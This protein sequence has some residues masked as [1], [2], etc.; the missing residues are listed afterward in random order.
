MNISQLPLNALRAFEASARL[1]SFTKAGMELRVSQTAVSHQVKSLEAI[2][3]VSLFDR[4]P[5]G[6]VLTDEGQ[7]LLPVLSDVFG[8]MSATLSRF[9][10]GNFQEVLTIGVVSTF[11]YGWLIDRLFD[12]SQA[13]P[14]VDV[15][16]KTNNNRADF[17]EDG[18]DYFIRFGDGAWHS[19][20]A[21]QLMNAPLSPVC[22]PSMAEAL[23]TP[24]DLKAVPLLRSYRLDEWSRWFEAAKVEPPS[25]RG[26]MFDSSVTMAAAAAKGAGV[27]LVPVTMF[28][29]ELETGRLNQPFPQTVSLGRYWLTWLK[30]RN[31]TLAMRQFRD[32]I[33]GQASAS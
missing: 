25:N 3:G 9:E 22:A 33:E 12:F 14:D 4:L 31:E 13:Y 32:W 11:A 20:N 6:V 1:G 23:K 30:S 5:R 18:L 16:L 21:L 29:E 19:T 27:A 7:T 24:A 8:R 10:H 17:L 28:R 26:W 15:R 2:L